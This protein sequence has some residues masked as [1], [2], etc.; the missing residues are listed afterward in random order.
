MIC[1]YH[2]DGRVGYFQLGADPLESEGWFDSPVAAAAAVAKDEAKKVADVKI[3]K[4]KK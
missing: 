4:P 1:K 3:D 2:K